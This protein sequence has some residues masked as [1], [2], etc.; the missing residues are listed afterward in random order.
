[1]SP[2][3]LQM[4]NLLVGGILAIVF[5]PKALSLHPD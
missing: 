5:I 4:K 2:A 3:D 1:M